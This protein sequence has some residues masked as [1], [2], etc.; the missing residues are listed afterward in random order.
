MLCALTSA[1]GFATIYTKPAPSQH[2]AAKAWAHATSFVL[3]RIIWTELF[4]LAAIIIFVVLCVKIGSKK[5]FLH[6]LSGLTLLALLPAF[7][8]LIFIARVF[9]MVY[10][11]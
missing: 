7:H 9:I 10:T 1:A 11:S 3:P 2:H 8:V 4:G 5:A 6:P